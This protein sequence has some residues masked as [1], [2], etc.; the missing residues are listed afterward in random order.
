LGVVAA[1]LA[2][3]LWGPRLSGGSLLRLGPS[4]L[5]A[6]IVVHSYLRRRRIG[7]GLPSDPVR[8]ARV[9]AE[10][11]MATLGLVGLAVVWAACIRE[12]Y[13]EL[14]FGVAVGPEVPMWVARR[15]TWAGLQQVA[16]QLF[17]WPVSR[18]LLGNAGAA[19][20]LA[21]TVFG[22]CHL[23]SPTLGL[24]TFAGACVWV[25]L[26][27][28][29][30]RLAPLVVSHALLWTVGFA[31]LPTRASFDMHVGATAYEALPQYRA[32]DSEQ[33]R[34]ILRT[35]TSSEYPV[36]GGGADEEYV[37]G[38]YRD[39][40]GRTPAAWEVEFWV[41]R[42]PAESRLEVAKKFVISDEL[43]DL[44]RQLGERYS[45]PFRR[46]EQGAQ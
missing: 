15:L 2:L 38:L 36:P 9:W 42:M 41:G 20:T 14:R 11:G 18:E 40:L 21:A 24:L 35:V 27:R 17:L 26:Y 46:Q 45:F 16:L 39:I 13:D 8:P 43:L 7:V 33:G 30:G 25:W 3:D 22:L 4:L 44:Q 12:P 6:A 37:G 31:A 29:G 32:L 1:L 28:R 19:V 10:A 34:A 23:P 5:I